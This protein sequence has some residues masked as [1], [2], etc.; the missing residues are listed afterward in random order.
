MQSN[1]SL[2][3]KDFQEINTEEWKN[4]II[5]DLKGKDYAESLVWQTKEGF[6]VDPF[7]NSENLGEAEKNLES[8]QNS[9]LNTENPEFGY[10]YWFNMQKIV[11]KDLEIANKQALKALQNGA[12]G[13]V[14]YLDSILSSDNLTVLLNN[15]KMQYCPVSFYLKKASGELLQNLLNF[16]KKAG[17]EKEKTSGEI[18]CNL[19]ET[20]EVEFYS[21][22]EQLSLFPGYKFQINLGPSELSYSEETADVLAK[23]VKLTDSLVERGLTA[24]KVLKQISIGIN[25]RNNY[26]FE[27]A[28]MRALRMLYT[29]IANCYEVEYQA[30][31][32][33]I[34]ASTTIKIDEATKEDPYLN[35]LSNT[36]QAMSG[37]I[38]G[39]TMLT[40]L[41]HNEGIEEVDEFSMHIARNV[42]CMLKDESYFDKAVDPAAGSYYLEKLTTQ[43]AEKTWELFQVKA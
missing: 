12:E 22:F 36:S 18:I 26:F 10:R 25:L 31:D 33:T 15:I 39:C 40:I 35:M 5:A 37:I 29:E 27:I 41:P 30:S 6:E 38:G 21:V 8:I 14:F 42:S 32:L 43:L 13:I 4:K 7:Y 20:N 1:E 11:V 28:R 23:V 16:T 24:D 3:F 2:S 19:S 17:I 34:S 9:Q